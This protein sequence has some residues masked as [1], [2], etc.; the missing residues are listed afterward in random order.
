MTDIHFD[1][2]SAGTTILSPV[3]GSVSMSVSL[4]AGASMIGVLKTVS[5][6]TACSFVFSQAPIKKDSVP[7]TE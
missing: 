2:T 1:L 4:G 6:D 3:S 5:F 7:R